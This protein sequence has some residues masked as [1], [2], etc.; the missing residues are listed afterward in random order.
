MGDSLETYA[1]NAPVTGERKL[2]LELQKQLPQPYLARALVAVDKD[3]PNGTE[4]KDHHNMSVLQ[5]HAAFFDRNKDGIIYPWETYQ[6]FRAAGFGFFTSFTSAILINLL[7][8]YRT[9]P[10]WLP[11]LLLS[12]HIKNIHRG[13]HGSDT[14][15]YD[16]EGRF[17]PS[18]FDAIFSKYG[19]TY[20]DAL[21]KDEISNMLK[22]N[23]N[24]GDCL[25][26]IMSLAE[27]R[28]LYRIGKDENG[29]LQKETIRGV[30]DGSLF[31][32]LEN[33]RASS[34]SKKA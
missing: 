12:I 5:Q 2:N 27:W 26:R 11:S 31:E 1:S 17:D 24:I 22:A 10:G 7:L 34:S 19:L 28:L 18:K 16:T 32:Q 30:Y 8:S 6:G 23:A 33:K 20:P 9:Q 3:H 14:E 13:K 4:G 15:T 21:T 25:G 29:L